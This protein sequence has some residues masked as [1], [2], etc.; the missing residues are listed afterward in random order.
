MVS[1][2]MIKHRYFI[3]GLITCGVVIGLLV[4]IAF[5]SRGGNGE[6][7]RIEVVA[8][9]VPYED[10]VIEDD[11]LF[12]DQAPVLEQV[13]IPGTIEHTFE[14][15]VDSAGNE[16]KREEV[17]TVTLV[18]KKDR[19]LRQGKLYRA[20]T[21]KT[22]QERINALFDALEVQDFAKAY[23]MLTESDRM[24]YSSDN[25][26][27]SAISTGF[28]VTT[29]SIKQDIRFEYPSYLTENDSSLQPIKEAYGDAGMT[30]DEEVNRNQALLAIVPVTVGFESP[31]IGNQEFIFDLRLQRENS[32]W[33]I[34]YFGPTE[35]LQVNRTRTRDDGGKT[36]G[37]P[38]GAEITVN[39]VIFFPYLN[40]IYLDYLLTNNSQRNFVTVDGEQVFMPTDAFL[41]KVTLYDGPGTAYEL[42]E[43]SLFN[44]SEDE[45]WIDQSAKGRLVLSPTPGPAID[46][47]FLTLQLTVTN[48][49]YFT[50]EA[51]RERDTQTYV[52]DV[53]FGEIKLKRQNRQADLQRE[54]AIRDADAAEADADSEPGTT[55]LP[56][57]E[58]AP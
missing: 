31:V 26:R 27:N 29:T 24:L 43:N 15:Q 28:K 18:E 23:P 1:F 25:L 42:L 3:P 6:N 49:A 46:T 52:S 32:N 47:L 13:G 11:N 39:N 30:A 55:R 14:I 21:L 35:M 37:N 45:V 54:G 17:K 7:T 16:I 53:D 58:S 44:Q 22:I 19:I 12:A 51:L 8:E 34:Y 10:Q 41:S 50:N 20:E 38:V 36:F 2:A 57:P 48:A 4:L 5:L 40:R 56:D 9:S 33:N